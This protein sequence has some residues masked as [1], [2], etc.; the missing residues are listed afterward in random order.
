M[1]STAPHLEVRRPS[2]TTAEFTVTTRPHPTLGLRAAL[3]VVFAGRVLLALSA[4]LLLHDKWAE[5][6]PSPPPPPS[7]SPQHQHHHHHHQ[8]KQTPSP[9][10]LSFLLDGDNTAASAARILLAALAAAHASPPGR[11]L[12]R[13]AAASPAWV[14][15]PLCALALHVAQLRPHTSESLLVLR[16]LGVQ[17]RSQGPGYLFSSRLLPFG[18]AGGSGGG[19][20]GGGGSGGGGGR[21]FIP[22]DKVRDVLIN[23]AFL[24]FEVRYYLVIVVEGE[25]ELVVVFPRLL[26]GRRT[27]EAVWR[28]VRGCLYEPEPGRRVDGEG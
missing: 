24:G 10:L 25:E 23:E 28:G 1:L 6:F 7:P 12:S 16:G 8:Q 26:P 17:T 19:G 15:A 9:S 21:R 5:V 22:V 13:V 4:L 20:G 14:L 11:L 2:P 27:V 18:P 3:A